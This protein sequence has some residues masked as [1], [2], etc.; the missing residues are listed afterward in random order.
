MNNFRSPIVTLVLPLTALLLAGCAQ[1][2]RREA[3]HAPLTSVGNQ[4]GALPAAVQNTIRAQTGAAE[5]HTIDPEMRS[6]GVVYK[7]NYVNE[8]LYPPL[9]V[10]ADGSVI[11]PDMSVAVGAVRDETSVG[12]GAGAGGIQLR[13]LPSPVTKVIDEYAPRSEVVSTDK[14][15]W[16]SRIVYIISFKNETKTPK[17]YIA[18][19]GTVLRDVHK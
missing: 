11:N 12:K 3:Y 18:A 1:D 15:T 9:Y 2:Q 8:D 7:I 5:I 10:A 13:D 14:E 19:D 16:G 4:F 6:I 17:L